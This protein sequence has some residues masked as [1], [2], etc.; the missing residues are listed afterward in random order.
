MAWGDADV[1]MRWRRMKCRWHGK[2][3]IVY[4]DVVIDEPYTVER[5]KSK[6]Q[7]ALVHVKK[8]VCLRLLRSYLEVY[9]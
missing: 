1:P 8:V 3:I 9:V 6:D 7:N 5:V 2:Q 4:N